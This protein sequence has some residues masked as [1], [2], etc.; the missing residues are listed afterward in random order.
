[1]FIR[2]KRETLL[3][4]VGDVV[5]FI[6]GLW[7]TLLVRYGVVPDWQIFLEHLYSFS[8]IYFLWVLVFFITGLYDKQTNALKRKLPSLIF[9]AQVFNSII[10]IIFF[11]FSSYTNVEIAPKFNLIIYLPV[12]LGLIIIWRLYLSDLIYLGRFENALIIGSSPEAMEIMS[13]VNRNPIYRMNLSIVDKVDA[14]VLGNVKNLKILTLIVDS[15]HYCHRESGLLLS[16]LMFLNIKF[17]DLESF[18]EDIFKKTPLSIVDDSWFLRNVSNFPRLV[19]DA[20]KRLMDISLSF[21]L[22]I[23][24][25]LLYPFIYFAIKLDDGGPVFIIQERIGQNNKIVNVIKLRTMKDN[26]D[27]KWPTKD[28]ER[29][30]KIGKFLRKTR[31]DELPQLWNVLRGDLSLIGPRQDI[32]GLGNELKNS[33]PYYQ[34]RNLIKPGLSGWA[35]INQDLPPHSLEETR[36]R[37]AYDFFYLKNRSLALDIEIALK[38]LKTLISRAGK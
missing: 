9:N 22:M 15:R 25:V 24:S 27:G 1:M 7:V 20:A 32:V 31:I 29:I 19:Y 17:I 37:L 5:F 6:L 34:M 21:V 2:W 18:Y 16:D 14:T 11:Y 13:E 12:S 35:Q 38:T 8:L 4:L 26:D 10:A 36:E 28:D 3:L 30:T 33:L 23:I